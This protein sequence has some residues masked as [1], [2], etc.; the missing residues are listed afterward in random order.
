MVG[1]LQKTCGICLKTMRGDTLKRP[2]KPHENKPYSMVTEYHST[3]DVVALKNKI[4]WGCDEYQR[5]LKLGRQ[6]KKIVQ[7][8]NV[9]VACL[10]KEKME[11]LELFENRGQVKDVE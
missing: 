6:I 7:E 11:S 8:H 9:H 3:V 4:L 1:N 5:R 10:D 2:M